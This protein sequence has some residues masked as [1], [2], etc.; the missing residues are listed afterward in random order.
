MKTIINDNVVISTEVLKNIFLFTIGFTAMIASENLSLITP[1]SPIPVTAQ[2]LCLLFIVYYLRTQSLYSIAAY[3]IY[4]FVT[5]TTPALAYFLPTYGYF[6]GMIFSSVALWFY[7]QIQTTKSAFKTSSVAFAALLFTLATGA[8]GL[9]I[10]L[11]MESAITAGFLA[12]VPIELVK[13]FIFT[14]AV[15]A[16]AQYSA[17]K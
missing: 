4:S 13:C 15:T 2:T 6:F 3:V 14:A 5:R 1:L 17:P 11:G 12:F 9:S 16:S 8:L 10:S 7:F